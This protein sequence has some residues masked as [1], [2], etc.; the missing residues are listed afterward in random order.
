[1]EIDNKTVDKIATLAKLQFE[2]NNKEE[3][4]NDLNRMLAF[5]NKINEVNT[6]EVEPL[7]H[8]NNEIN[9]LREDIVQVTITQEESLKNAPQKDSDYFKIPKVLSK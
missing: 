9:I 7:I 4:K 6:D 1:M 5:V 8:M 2:D 3:I